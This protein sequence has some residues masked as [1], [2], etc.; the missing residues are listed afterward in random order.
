MFK[1]LRFCMIANSGRSGAEADIP[2]AHA[3][4][5]PQFGWIVM[6]RNL[7]MSQHLQQRLF[8]RLG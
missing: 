5:R 3:Q 6:Q 1:K 4:P 2:F 7:G 8:F